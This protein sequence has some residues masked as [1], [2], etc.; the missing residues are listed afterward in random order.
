MVQFSL[1]QYYARLGLRSLRRHP[2]LTALMVLTLA[3]GVAASMS[4]LTILHVMSGDPI[5]Q[6]SERLFMPLLDN[7]PRE[8]FNPLD[9]GYRDTQMSYRDITALLAGAPAQRSSALYTVRA[10]IEQARADLPVLDSGGMAVNRDFFAMF[11]APFLRGQAWSESDDKLGAD[12]VVLS[13]HLAEALFGSAD[14]VGRRVRMFGHDYQVTGVVKPWRVAPRFYALNSTGAFGAP[15]EFWIPFRSAIRHETPTKSGMSCYQQRQPGWQGLLDSECTWIQMWFE[16][17]T[18]AG[19]AELQAYL[20]NYTSEQR[21]LGRFLRAV[22]NELHDVMQW[23]R[24]ENVVGRDERLSA[25]LAVG[26]LLLCLVN[27][28]GLLLAK[29]S[30]RFAEVGVRR[31]LGAS[32]RDI[33]QQCLVEASVVGLAGG[34]A[35]LALAY[36]ALA[37]IGMQSDE[38]RRAAQMDWQ[39]LLGT[40]AMAL[41]AALLA[42]LLPTW[43]ACQVTPALQLKSQ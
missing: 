10:A 15:E 30:A 37:L 17:R 14:P 4:T 28:V 23:L 2:A 7:G 12:M 25:G 1:L 38:M 24:H 41:A 40:V 26:F 29:F 11:D 5:P 8:G 31:A 9:R 32:R 35:G 6:K 42:G 20:D 18:S 21:K 43:R 34:A 13:A 27:T 39:M 3:I 16:M 22:P 33:F 36:G 19:R